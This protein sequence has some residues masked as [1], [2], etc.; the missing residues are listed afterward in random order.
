MNKTNFII[1]TFYIINLYLLIKSNLIQNTSI[2]ILI[3]GF[4]FL[5]L[6]RYIYSQKRL[7]N[8][9]DENISTHFKNDN[10]LI[11]FINKA[12]KNETNLDSNDEKILNNSFFSN[13]TH[14]FKTPIFTIKGL[15]ETLEN[16]AIDDKNINKTF[17]R[18]ISKNVMRIESLIIDLI[19]LSQLS[20]NNYNLKLEEVKLNSI[21]EYVSEIFKEEA[22][23]KD[24]T[25]SIPNVE[26]I[27]VLGNYD[28]LISIFSNLISNAIFYSDKGKITI[29]A[30]KQ[31]DKLHIKIID[32]GIGIAE[33]NHEKIFNRF[34]RVNPDR[35]RKTGGTG[36]GLA[37]VKHLVKAHNSEIIVN[38][39]EDQGSEFSFTLELIN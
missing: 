36:L 19:Q 29:L 34:Y 28:G 16:G 8:L 18:K 5:L 39:I 22:I 1:S 6:Y 23:K 27:K 32:N 12:L 24:L 38:S 13:V 3:I 25:L 4:S 26:G 2:L 37:I 11:D 31:L 30:K 9:L 33:E 10:E 14:E 7:I 20:S 35:S 21:M 17:V 15:L